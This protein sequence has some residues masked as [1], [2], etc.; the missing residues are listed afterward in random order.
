MAENVLVQH[1]LF[2]LANPPISRYVK[3]KTALFKYN[4]CCK[5]PKDR[6]DVWDGIEMSV[7]LATLLSSNLD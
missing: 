3:Y 7:K 4:C 2:H 5:G 1:M 6:G